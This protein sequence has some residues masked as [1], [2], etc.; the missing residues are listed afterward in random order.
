MAITTA[1]HFPCNYDATD[2]H[3]LYNALGHIKGVAGILKLGRLLECLS[4]GY[5]GYLL[6]AVADTGNTVAKL[7]VNKFPYPRKKTRGN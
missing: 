3:C 6:F 4:I 2:Q 1:V 7:S 5:M